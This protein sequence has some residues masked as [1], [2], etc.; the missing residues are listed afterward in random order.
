MNTHVLDN[1]HINMFLLIKGD[2]TRRC[3]LCKVVKMMYWYNYSTVHH[4]INA[5]FY[6]TV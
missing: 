2:G 3:I 1:A 5:M 4:I 6:R